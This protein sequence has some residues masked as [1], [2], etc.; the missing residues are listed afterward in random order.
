MF[1][2]L[3]VRVRLRCVAV[4]KS[5]DQD[6][7]SS[8]S[9]SDYEDPIDTSADDTTPT[10]T[11]LTGARAVAA[12]PPLPDDED[13]LYDDIEPT[14]VVQRPPITTTT[15]PTTKTTTTT[16]A[17]AAAAAVVV[18]DDDS[19]EDDLIYEVCD[20]V[21]TP[22]RDPAVTSSRDPVVTLSRD[23]G[24]TPPRDSG[25]TPPRDP[26]T[27]RDY[28]NMYYGR[29]DCPTSRE[30]ELSFR[31]GDVLLIV[32]RQFDEFGWWVGALNGSVGLVPKQYVTPA[33]E[34]VDT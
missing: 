31:R 4:V 13:E 15:R 14:P 2:R 11:S 27:S 32:S 17:T 22:S 29:W 21:V 3:Y 18:N 25:V 6:N 7:V 24:I 30:D 8:A 28:A 12:A 1:V 9:S 23:L 16:T 34:L 19:F 33:Y 10:V 5:F 26:M 20:P